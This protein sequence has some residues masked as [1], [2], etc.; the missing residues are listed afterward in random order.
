MH[1]VH[2]GGYLRGMSLAASKPGTRVTVTEE[3]YLALERASATK[4]EYRRG[5]IV[6]MAGGSPRHS[7]VASKVQTAL[8]IALRGR[9]CIVYNSDLRVH[10]SSI[11]S[12]LYP[13]VTVTC[14]KPTFHS[15]DKDSLT[16]PR[17]IVEVLSKSTEARDRGGKFHDYQE[18][19][20]L[21]HYV[22]VSQDE[23][24]VEH[25]ER[26]PSGRWSLGNVVDEGTLRIPSMGVEIPL[27]DIY[28]GLEDL[29]ETSPSPAPPS[30]IQPV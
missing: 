4:N 16:N 14:E 6:A 12:Y 1:W 28:A 21:Q 2:P 7:A 20:S 29:E 25:F 11:G 23:R 26:L 5:R 18:I 8:T 30:S 3:Q 10:I 15:K 27:A 13:D 24:R 22:L 17:L 9:P 19:P